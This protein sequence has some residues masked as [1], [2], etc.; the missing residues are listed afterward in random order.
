MKRAFPVI[1]LCG[2]LFPISRP[3]LQGEFSGQDGNLA[4]GKP[5]AC[6][7]HEGDYYPER[8]VDGDPDLESRWGAN[9]YPQ[10]HKVDLEAVCEIEALRMVTYWDGWRYYQYAIEVSLDDESWTEVV[11]MSKNTVPS[12]SSGFLHNIP[13]AKARYVR[14]TLLY[15]SANPGLHLVEVRAFTD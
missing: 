8:A 1:M 14:S 7:S 6:S 12:T 13:L 4:L 9:P 3:L 5:A 2:L 10:W 11:D 15:N